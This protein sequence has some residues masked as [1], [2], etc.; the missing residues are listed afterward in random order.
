VQPS[1]LKPTRAL[2][3]APLDPSSMARACL[4]QVKA[5]DKAGF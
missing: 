1:V 5:M 4:I 2:I 3:V